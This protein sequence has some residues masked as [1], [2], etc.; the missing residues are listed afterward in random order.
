MTLG[1]DL[2]CGQTKCDSGHVSGPN[3]DAAGQLH[4]QLCS[5][6]C[7][8]GTGCRPASLCPVNVLVPWAREC[9]VCALCAPRTVTPGFPPGWS[10]ESQTHSLPEGGPPAKA[11]CGLCPGSCPGGGGGADELMWKLGVAWCCLVF[12][13]V[14]DEASDSLLL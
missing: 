7:E 13:Q 2:S 10:A 5:T 14:L 8:Q 12:E 1:S 4:S 6:Q 9:A 11:V 3:R